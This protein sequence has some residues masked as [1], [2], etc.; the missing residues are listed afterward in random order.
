MHSETCGSESCSS[1][2]PVDYCVIGV[3]PVTRVPWVCARPTYLSKSFEMLN[4]KYLELLAYFFELMSFA[5]IFM[6][7]DISFKRL[8]L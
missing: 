8:R 4:W 6:N 7:N 5:A 2:P 1:F 3:T